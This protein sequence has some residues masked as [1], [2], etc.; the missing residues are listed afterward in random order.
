MIQHFQASIGHSSHA[1]PLQLGKAQA[2]CGYF[3]EALSLALAFLSELLDD[4]EANSEM[5]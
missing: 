5:S 2:C 1:S 3:L 4:L